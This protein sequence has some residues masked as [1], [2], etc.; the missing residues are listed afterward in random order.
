M[1]YNF[2][3]L[4][5]FHQEVIYNS[6]DELDDIVKIQEA[7]GPDDLYEIEFKINGIEIDFMKF[8]DFVNTNMNEFIDNAAKELVQNKLNEIDDIYL[9]FKNSVRNIGQPYISNDEL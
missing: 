9:Q 4:P 8:M 5:T 7:L 3:T 6:L 2:F 1:K